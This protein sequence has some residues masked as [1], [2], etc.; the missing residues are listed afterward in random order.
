MAKPS[1]KELAAAERARQM[2]ENREAKQMTKIL[3]K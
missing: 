1:K 2:V 3:N